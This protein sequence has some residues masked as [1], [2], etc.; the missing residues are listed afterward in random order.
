MTKPVCGGEGVG[1]LGGGGG[2]DG[3]S[4]CLSIDWLPKVWLLFFPFRLYLVDIN[5]S[6]CTFSDLN[7]I[8]LMTRSISLR[9]GLVRIGMLDCWNIFPNS[10]DQVKTSY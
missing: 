9:D 10:N 5:A 6:A 2:G 7:S 8:G 1:D 4:R 3:V